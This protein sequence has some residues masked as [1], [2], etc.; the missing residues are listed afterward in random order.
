MPVGAPPIVVPPAAS[1]FLDEPMAGGRVG[2]LPSSINILNRYASM[3][4]RPGLQHLGQILNER[5]LGSIWFRDHADTVQ[6][7]IGQPTRW[8]HLN[9]ATRVLEDLSSTIGLFDVPTDDLPDVPTDELPDVVTDQLGIPQGGALHGSDLMPVTFCLFEQGGRQYVIGVNDVDPPKQWTPGATSYATVEDAPIARTVCV[10]ANR[11]LF[12]YLTDADGKKLPQRLKW[13]KVGRRLDYSDLAQSD[14]L[15]V[16]DHIVA[17]RP[18]GRK[19]GAVYR[20]W[21]EWLAVAVQGSDARAFD[22]ILQDNKPG[23]IGPAAVA[24][25]GLRHIYFGSDLNVYS[26]DGVQAQ[27]VAATANLLRGRIVNERKRLVSAA[28]SPVD[29]EVWIALPL[30]ADDVPTH[31]LIWSELTGGVFLGRV[32]M[33]L[34]VSHFGTWQAELDTVT[35]ALP[36]I[37]TDQ[38]PDVPTDALGFST[39]QVL[40]IAG[41]GGPRSTIE[42]PGT[43]PTE[44][45]VV[46]T[47][48]DGL[49]DVPTDTLPDI[50]T[51]QLGILAGGT[52]GEP[53]SMAVGAL[54][55]ALFTVDGSEDGALGS[56]F[57]AGLVDV[58]TNQLPDVPTDQLPDVPTDQLGLP[59]AIETPAPAQPI[60]VVAEILLPVKAGQDYE[61]DG[62]EAMFEPPGALITVTVRLGPTLDALTDFPL[63]TLDPSTNQTKLHKPG[64]L[65]G[66]VVVVRFETLTRTA[67]RLRRLELWSWERRMDAL[68]S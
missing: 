18:M 55:G 31:L 49:P 60:Q 62:V 46:D 29:R 28:Y 37:P 56:V 43:A 2:L 48:T 7:V 3:R 44:G 22:F 42:I 21:S 23:P 14:L 27:I 13:S 16:F 63:G 10:V 33:D 45:T 26:F 65:R 57:G 59:G 41:A 30:D 25:V 12:G 36:D 35:D 5:V 34:A 24:I 8:R 61:F 40:L 58:P 52:P 64:P 17:V 54:G 66:R 51:D 19:A 6:L 67:I 20:E 53:P 15:D 32:P 1:V 38:L 4:S 9:N 47:P 39:R 50:P 11:L 68:A